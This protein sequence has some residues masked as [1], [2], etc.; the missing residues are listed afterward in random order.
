MR[1]VRSISLATFRPFCLLL[2]FYLILLLDVSGKGGRSGHLNLPPGES[3]HCL[4][5]FKRGDEKQER[6]GLEETD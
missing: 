5:A 4:V 2:L 1:K 6:K 3:E